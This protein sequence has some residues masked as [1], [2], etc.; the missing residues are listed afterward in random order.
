MTSTASL[1]SD[2]ADGAWSCLPEPDAFYSDNSDEL[3]AVYEDVMGVLDGWIPFLSRSSLYSD[4]GGFV[5]W[6][7]DMEERFP[8]RVRD[9]PLPWFLHDGA[10]ELTGRPSARPMTFRDFCCLYRPALHASYEA[11]VTG[12][13]DWSRGFTPGYLEPWARLLYL[14]A[15]R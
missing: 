5:E 7:L 2:A 8:F 1:T 11:A 12:V 3:M 10:P 9:A 14:R 15:A 13:L 6:V 4:V